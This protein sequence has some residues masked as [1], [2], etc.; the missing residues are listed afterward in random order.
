[1]AIFNNYI[2]TLTKVIDFPWK[3]IILWALTGIFL[4][5]AAY[6]TKFNKKYKK[7]N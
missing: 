7:E 6:C 3:G 1:M 2:V 5:M 4:L